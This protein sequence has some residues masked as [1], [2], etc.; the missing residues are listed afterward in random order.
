MDLLTIFGLALLELWIAIP[1]GLYMKVDVNTIL[2][3]TMTGGITGVSIVIFAGSKIRSHLVKAEKALG[4]RKSWSMKVWEKYGVIGLGLLSPFLTGAPIGAALAITFGG[5]PLP[6]LFWFS[7][8]V[9]LWSLIFMYFTKAGLG[10]L[11]V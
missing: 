3:L 6:G 11:G 10:S 4:E 7:L 2:V 9:V 8:G 1:A 5:K